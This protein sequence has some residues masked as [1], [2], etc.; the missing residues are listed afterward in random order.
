MAL[1]KINPGLRECLVALKIRF[2]KS[3]CVE[4]E[5]TL[6]LSPSGTIISMQSGSGGVHNETRSF[7][8]VYN[9]RQLDSQDKLSFII[10][11]QRRRSMTV[12]IMALDSSRLAKQ[13]LVVADVNT[14]LLA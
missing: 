7:Y 3:H 12:A 10:V 6:A 4:L 1:T 2:V 9:R 8:Q 13:D 5:S 11:S 14:L